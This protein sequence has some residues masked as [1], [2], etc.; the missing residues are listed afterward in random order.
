ML[1][2]CC[3]RSREQEFNAVSDDVREDEET[4]AELHQRVDDLREAMWDIC[5]TRKT[6]AEEERKAVMSTGWLEDRLGIL[7]NDYITLMQ[8]EVDRFQDTMRLIK[9]YYKCASLPLSLQ[10]FKSC[11]VTANCFSLK[12]NGGEDFGGAFQ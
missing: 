6:Q 10:P 8:C 11:D 3:F 7:S 1:T 9:D 12:G 5:D 4:R 2:Y